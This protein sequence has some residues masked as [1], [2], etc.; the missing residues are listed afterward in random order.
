[1]PGDFVA[2]FATEFYSRAVDS[3]AGTPYDYPYS[4][5]Q[6]IGFF[7]L[8]FFP[9]L[10]LLVFA[11]RI[12]GRVS[13]KQF[14]WDDVLISIAMILS[15]AEISCSYRSMR[16][17]FIGVRSKDIPPEADLVIGQKW[18]YIVMILYN[19]IL[20]LVKTSALLF[21]LRLGGQKRQVGHAIIGLL[22]F[23]AALMAGI[24]VSNIFQ[25]QPISYF[26][27]RVSQN[28]P[29]GTCFNRRAFYVVTA[30]LTIITDLLV[31]M[32]PFWIF[33]GL[34]LP[35]RVRM[36][37]IG[38][39]V[40]GG[41]VT[42]MSILRLTWLVETLYHPKLP[43]WHYDIRFTYSFV[44]TNLAIICACAPALRPLFIRWWPRFFSSQRSRSSSNKTSRDPYGRSTAQRTHRATTIRSSHRNDT[45]VLK[46][47]KGRTQIFGHSPT[48]SEEEIMT[49]DGIVKT[50]E[51]AVDYV[52]KDSVMDGDHR[53]ENQTRFGYGT[54]SHRSWNE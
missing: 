19:P 3:T 33:L 43:D 31:L 4:R 25:C 50:S 1:M 10:A 28:P 49:Y 32:L 40:M 24:F 2:V 38:V 51:V 23:N 7:I 12:Y 37:L 21:L 20:A 36:A 53:D 47:L 18:Q 45:F 44:E 54:S 30:G 29:K 14:G 9:T 16:F 52:C 27:L 5:L 11:L 39:F 8:F 42:I 34:K 17:N 6:H 41:I 46:D 15:I 26:W 48:N 13:A 35:L 22:T